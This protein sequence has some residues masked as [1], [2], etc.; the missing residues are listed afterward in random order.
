MGESH[1]QY[2]TLG[3]SH[4][5]YKTLLESRDEYRTLFEHVESHD[6]HSYCVLRFVHVCIGTTP[7]VAFVN[8][9][10]FVGDVK[11]LRLP[12]FDGF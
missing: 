3:E 1:D 9:S 7:S 4:D 12:H 6:K 10:G 2:K 8:A 5:Q 11:Q